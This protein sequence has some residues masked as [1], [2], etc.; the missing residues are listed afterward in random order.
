LQEIASIDAL[1]ERLG[2]RFK[3]I[4][5]LVQAL[6]HR[7]S[8]LDAP[9]DSNERM[10]FL[11]D[12]IV[13]M[14]ACH[15]LFEAFPDATEGDLAKAKAF[16]VSEP[17]LAKAALAFGIDDAVR[18]SPGEEA[19]GGRLRRSILSDTF[20]AVI[21]AIYLDQG[22]NAARRVVRL[23]LKEFMREVAANTYHQDFK[24]QLQ[25]RLQARTK[26]TPH[27]RITAEEG[28]DHDKTFTAEAMIGRKVIGSGSGKSKKEAE[29]SAAYT[30]LQAI[31]EKP[32]R[33]QKGRLSSNQGECSIL[34]DS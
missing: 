20:E 33:I 34:V 3:D 23:A 5:I 8:V 14:V 4:G 7:S 16:L 9:M 11:G 2:V 12:A 29:Q 27:Y 24:S 19:S 28:A 6:R 22:M 10:E 13:G 25:E 32:G 31:P 18:V 15:G 1:Q 26:R 30:A 17:T 21:A